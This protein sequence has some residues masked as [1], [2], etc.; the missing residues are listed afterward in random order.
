MNIVIDASIAIKWFKDEDED[1]VDL[2][3]SIQGKKLTG[4][5]EIIVPDLFFLEVLNAFLKKPALSQ[6]YISN[7][8]EIL[9]KMNMGIVY[10]D[11]EILGKTI[12]IA[13]KNNLT[14]YD[15]LYIATAEVKDAILYTEDKKI[16]SCRKV[17][18]FIRHIKDYS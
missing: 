16:L 9:L 14:F 10:P 1:Y 3:L 15:A 12:N 5:V 13:L 18:G 2:A 8:K 11:S 4:E 17:Y 7:I 6:K